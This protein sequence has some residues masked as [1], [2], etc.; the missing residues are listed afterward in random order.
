MPVTRRPS[1][2]RAAA[3]SRRALRLHVLE[4]EGRLAPAVFNIPNGNVAAFVTAVKA[5]NANNQPDTIN[6]AIGGTYT[7]TDEAVAEEYTALPQIA[8]DRANPANSVTIN[9]NGATLQRSTAPGVRKIRLLSITGADATLNDLTFANGD[10]T[11]LD[12]MGGGVR[13][14][15]LTLALNR[16]RFV[17]NHA[18]HWGGGLFV[19][20]RFRLTVTDCAF[21][22]NSCGYYGAALDIENLGSGES[23]AVVRGTLIEGNTGGL[24]SRGLGGLMAWNTSLTMSNCVV[25]GNTGTDD[26]G[27]LGVNTDRPVTATISDCVF[28]ENTAVNSAGMRF[29]V[30]GGVQG[31]VPAQVV[32]TTITNNRTTGS[33]GGAAVTSLSAPVDFT[34][35]TIDGNVCRSGAAIGFAAFLGTGLVGGSFTSCTIT[36][37]PNGGI[38]ASGS[39]T[40]KNTVVAGNGAVSGTDISGP[41]VSLGYNFIGNG[42]GATITGPATGDRVGTAAAPLD[43]RLGPLQDNGGPTLTRLPVPDSPLINAGD[44]NFQP[45]P[46]FDQRGPG[47]PRVGNGRI[48]IGATE[49]VIAHDLAV[50]LTDGR[51]LV[52]AGGTTTYTAI[53]QNAGDFTEA[54][55]TFSLPV[56]PGAAAMTWTSTTAGG[57][58]GTTPSGTGP[59]SDTLD[60]PIGSSVTYTVTLT[61]APTAAGQLVATAQAVAPTGVSE[62]DLTNNTATDPDAVLVGG[63]ILAVGMGEGGPP[64]VK[65]YGARDGVPL[66]SFPAYDPVFRGGVSVAVADFTAD[67]V[68]DVVA[69]AGAGGAPQVRVFDGATG[70]VLREWTAYDPAF[71]GGVFVA[72]GDVTGDGT[73]DVVTG[74]GPGGGPHMKVFD[75]ANGALVRQWMAYDTAFRGGVSVAAGDIDGDNRADVLTGAGPGGGP[76]VKVFSGATGALLTQAFAYEADFRGGVWVT[77]GDVDGDGRAE[78]IT[79]PGE[80]GGPFVKVL[81]GT[82]LSLLR[83]FLAYDAAFRGGTRVAAVDATGDGKAEI[84]TAAGPGGGP[85]VRLFDGG[86]GSEVYGLMAFDPALRRGIFIGAG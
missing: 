71:T 58:V 55:A 53:V 61:L 74:A 16:C 64:E 6:L 60:L 80:G 2:R 28:T 47:F 73:P 69:A 32:R 82:D 46:Q 5:C 4:L 86:T 52:P 36:N 14:T 17:G 13:A 24:T 49:K 29:T 34:N 30:R 43:P 42:T 8:L 72:G 63:R 66:Y 39:V 3:P 1:V 62:A 27:G 12:G 56:P 18:R 79:A 35:C 44:P 78:V 75:G 20:D 57:A 81:R 38:G 45:P 77:A 50:T 31:G 26:G 51:R 25:R 37:N 48:D 76:H 68:P 85:H 70:N 15:N 65:L 84:V 22:Q 21:L 83:G 23:S 67:G 59:I 10:A 33:F 9:G 11:A 41:I 19:E 54:G 40:M 7:F